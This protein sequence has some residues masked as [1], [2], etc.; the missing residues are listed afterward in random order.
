MSDLGLQLRRPLE[1]RGV[2]ALMEKRDLAFHVALGIAI[3]MSLVFA[4]LLG[5]IAEASCG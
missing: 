1:A 3:A 5:T 2:R 4:F